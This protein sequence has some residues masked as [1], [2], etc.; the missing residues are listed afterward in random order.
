MAR[1][2]ILVIED[3]PDILELIQFNL[4][5]DGFKVVTSRTG[6]EG[7]RLAGELAPDLIVLDLMLP[8]ISGVE[9]CRLLRQEAKTR[10]VPIIM[11]TA[12][13]SES[14]VVL[15]LEVGADDYITKPFSVRELSARIRAVLRRSQAP[16]SEA[17]GQ[18]V[19]AG[20]LQ[21]DPA[22]HEARIHGQAVEVDAG[23]VPAPDRPGRGPGQSIHSRPATGPDHRWAGH[24]HRPQ[25]GCSH[26]R[27]PAQAGQ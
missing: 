16:V 27:P 20:P 21:L 26:P 19:R 25:R 6:E 17:P 15:G 10:D 4:E 24:H 23:R 22:R 18:I 12:R 11:A 3:E 1:K 5:S 13:D 8:D 9:V 7:H 2:T 14:D